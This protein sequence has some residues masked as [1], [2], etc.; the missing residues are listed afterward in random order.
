MIKP[1]VS[2]AALIMVI[3]ILCWQGCTRPD[4][5][6]MAGKGGK[7]TL[8][9]AAKHHTQ[10]VDSVM[11]YIKYNEQDLPTGGVFDDSVRTKI[12]NGKPVA[13]FT[14]LKKGSYY[15]Y[16]EGYDYAQNEKVAGGGPYIISEETIQEY[17]QVV[18]GGH[19]L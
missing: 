2:F 10:Y 7:A 16:C 3:T 12:K 8:V 9:L 15:I 19:G 13:H 4:T 6:P 5:K 1:I 18:G 14:G 17:D 11:C